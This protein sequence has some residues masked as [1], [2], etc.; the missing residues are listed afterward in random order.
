MDLEES[1]I[2][3]WT[4]RSSYNLFE[5]LGPLSSGFVEAYWVPGWIDTEVGYLPMI[6]ASPYSPRGRNPQ[7]PAARG[8]SARTGAKAR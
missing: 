8:F 5:T 4:L 2:P 7:F 1:R 3:L 6:T